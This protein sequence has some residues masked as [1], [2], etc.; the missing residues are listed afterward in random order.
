MEFSPAYM[1]ER[2]RHRVTR[3]PFELKLTQLM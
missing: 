2:R 3:L 1:A